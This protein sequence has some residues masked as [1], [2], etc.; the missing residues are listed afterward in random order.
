MSS[1]VVGAAHVER[2]GALEPENDPILVVHTHGVLPFQVPGKRVQPIPGRYLQ[3]VELRD[4]I[5]LVQFAAN[6]RPQVPGDPA[7]GL[8]IDAVPDVPGR[9]VGQRPNHR[10]AL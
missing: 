10:L 7:G 2:V 1:V 9:V 4:G 3:V 8:R 6:D 5:D